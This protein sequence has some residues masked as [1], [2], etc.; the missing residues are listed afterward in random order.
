[1]RAGLLLCVAAVAFSVLADDRLPCASAFN[2]IIIDRA[3]LEDAR[4]FKREEFAT[5]LCSITRPG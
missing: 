5:M 1:M 3:E 4:W 2:D